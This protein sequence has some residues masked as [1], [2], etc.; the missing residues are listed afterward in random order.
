MGRVALG[1]PHLSTGRDRVH[2]IC[3][4]SPGEEARPLLDGPHREYGPAFSAN[5]RWL[6]YVS[7]ET[8]RGEV[9]V[10]GYP[11]GERQAVS[12]G[13]GVG[14][15]WSSRGDELFFGGDHEGTRTLFAVP[16]RESGDGLEIG[17]PEPLFAMVTPLPNGTTVAYEFPSNANTTYDVFQ[18]GQRFV[19]S[20]GVQEP[21]REIVI[22]QNFFEEARRLAPKN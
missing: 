22:V 16:V 19:M 13:G 5:G 11:A 3:V 7:T 9:Y 21:R 12:T 1:D 6:A 8:G 14:P 17:E 20:R 10:Q 4:V 15:R 18:D 2:D